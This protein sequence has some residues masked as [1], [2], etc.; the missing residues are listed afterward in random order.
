[1]GAWFGS[2]GSGGA[3]EEGW[4]AGGA[5]QF[6]RIYYKNILHHLWKIN[7]YHGT[8]LERKSKFLEIW[9]FCSTCDMLLPAHTTTTVVSSAYEIFKGFEILTF[10]VFNAADRK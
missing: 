7:A 9:I 8:K 3:G 5:A 1:M 2:K 6:V 10:Q 4:G